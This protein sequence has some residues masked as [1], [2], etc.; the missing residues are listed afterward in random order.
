MDYLLCY[1][2]LHFTSFV[3]RNHFR[4]GNQHKSLG[5]SYKKCFLLVSYI[6]TF[7]NA[8]CDISILQ[9]FGFVIGLYTWHFLSSKSGYLVKQFYFIIHVFCELSLSLYIYIIFPRKKDLYVIFQEE[10]RTCILHVSPTLPKHQISPFDQGIHFFFSFSVPQ[11]AKEIYYNH[12]Q[13]TLQKI[14]KGKPINSLSL[15]LPWSTSSLRKS[16]CNTSFLLF[17]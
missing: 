3:Y 11:E 12:I 2:N 14:C 1:Q 15:I 17:L 9:Y 5:K 6:K 8:P 7:S 10:I 13:Y 16:I 4:H